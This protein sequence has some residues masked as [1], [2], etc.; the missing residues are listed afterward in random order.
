MLNSI[1]EQYLRILIMKPE[2][3]E[4]NMTFTDFHSQLTQLKKKL[5][6]TYN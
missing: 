1:E 5:A 3:G 2:F 6:H 4:G